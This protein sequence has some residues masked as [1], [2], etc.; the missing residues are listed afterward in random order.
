MD[1]QIKN[2]TKICKFC[3]TEIPTDAKICPNCRKKQTS[4]LRKTAKILL[5]FCIAAFLLTFCSN[6]QKF[7]NENNKDKNPRKIS[8]GSSLEQEKTGTSG[9][10]FQTGDVVETENL[11]ISFLSAEQYVSDNEFLQPKEGYEYWKFTFKVENISDSDQAVSSLMDWECFAD[12]AKADQTYIGDDNGLD[13]T[14][15][16]GRETQGSIYFEIPQ[17]SS[18]IELEYKISYFSDN[19]IIL[20]QNNVPYLI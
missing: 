6:V 5:L 19:K 9:N 4:M 14:L 12:N 13:A 18:Q 1:K 15:S 16:S 3:K 2:Q 10:V 8:E 17:G 20:R 7:K 11:R